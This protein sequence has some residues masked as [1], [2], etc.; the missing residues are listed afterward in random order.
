MTAPASKFGDSFAAEEDF[1]ISVV[2]AQA[3]GTPVI[4]LSRGG[5]GEI[6]VESP[7]PER[8]TGLF[9]NE[10]SVASI[11]DAVERFE[12][13]PPFRAEVCRRNAVRFTTERFRREFLSVVERA[14]D[15]CRVPADSAPE[16]RR[17]RSA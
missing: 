16:I 4:A 7:D 11:V 9:F 13:S 17:W 1:G 15:A 2:E 14:V 6:V 3:C 12:Q 5:V 8:A 10:Q